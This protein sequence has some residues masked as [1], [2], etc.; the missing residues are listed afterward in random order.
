MYRSRCGGPTVAVLMVVGSVFAS[1]ARAQE[2]DRDKERDSGRGRP[3]EDRPREATGPE[4]PAQLERDFAFPDPDR[5][6]GRPRYLDPYPY[7]PSRYP[8][9][10]YGFPRRYYYDDYTYR[11]GVPLY[12]DPYSDGLER[13]Y[14]QGVED[15]RNFERFQIEAERGLAA[16]QQAMAAG[17]AAFTAGEFGAAARHFLYAATLNQGGPASRICA[18]HAQIAL[19]HYEPAIGLLRRAFELQP[20]LVYLPMDMRN[21]YRDRADFLTHLDA[22]RRAVDSDRGNGDLWFLLGYCHYYSDDMARAAEALTT[23]AKIR[24][25]DELITRLADLARMSVWG[26]ERPPASPKPQPTGQNR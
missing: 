4:L 9:R 8:R 11:F 20:K 14:R 13:A 19:G 16:Y 17:H 22:L 26:S 21:A 10:R 24:P 15:G 2:Q 1:P 7:R 5:P 12:A 25:E 23:A 18:A 6:W 3:D